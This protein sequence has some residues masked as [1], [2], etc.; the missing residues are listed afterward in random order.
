MIRVGVRCR[1]TRARCPG[2]GS[3]SGRVHGSYLRF[4]ADVPVV[5]RRVVLRLRVRRFT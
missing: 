5:G 2:C 3:W 4:P 1:T